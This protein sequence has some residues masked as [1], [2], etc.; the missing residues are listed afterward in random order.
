MLWS[1]K[2]DLRNRDAK[3]SDDQ[4]AEQV[5]TDYAIGASNIDYKDADAWLLRLKAG[6]TPE[7]ANKFDATGPKLQELLIPLQWTSSAAP[8][9]A[10]IA[11]ETGGIYV[12]NVFLNVTSTS[13][14]TPSGAQTTV[15]YNVT[16]D[17]NNDWKIT[18]VGGMD[19]ALPGK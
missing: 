18:D 19:G 1:A 5:A 6:T 13:A 11:S 9:E 14:Q 3:S 4:H 17:R 8:I 15:T 7:L 10:A 2:S 16:V 12:V